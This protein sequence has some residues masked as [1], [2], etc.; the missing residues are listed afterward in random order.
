MR[1]SLLII[2]LLSLFCI[3]T[4]R[5][6][7]H[8]LIKE[9]EPL[10]AD[11][12]IVLIGSVPDRALEA[13]DLYRKGFSDKI[14]MV[15]SDAFSYKM[16]EEH[17]VFLQTNTVQTY[18]AIAGLGVPEDNI[19]I[20]PG[21]A[22]DTGDEALTIREYLRSHTDLDSLLLVTSPSHTRR[23]YMIFKQAFKNYPENIK[24]FVVPSKY[25]RFRPEKWW[26]RKNDIQIVLLEYMKFINFIL[27]EKQKI[28]N[29]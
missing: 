3:V 14:I 12:I 19:I 15:R 13:A 26:T 24:F 25:S 7:G 17:D 10:N 2:I 21:D 11:A 23:A 29:T 9:D 20:L 5:N 22:T 4:C 6:A 1:Y 28:K 18:L 8:W 27:F 16:L